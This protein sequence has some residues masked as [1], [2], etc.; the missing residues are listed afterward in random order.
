[1][2]I[3]VLSDIHGNAPALEAVLAD[4]PSV[5]AVVSCGDAVGY[6]PDAP[7]VVDRLRSLRVAMVR[8]NHELMVC[9]LKPV[10]PERAAAYRAE[11]TRAAL[12]PRQLRW[13]RTLPATLEFERDGLSICIRHASPWDEE[14]Y[15]YPDSPALKEIDLP[16]NH[17]LLLGHT[18]YPMQV[19]CGNGWLANPGSVGQPRDWNPQ[20]AY[21][22]LDT[23]TGRWEQRRVSYDHGAY[24][25]RLEA[26]GWEPR[27][28]A[29]LGR[30]RAEL[31]RS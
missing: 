13:L 1:M 4:L 27:T 7:A 24:Q 9:G 21:A 23:A 19:C 25:H 3:A 14:T 20:A 8:G 29:L 18:H 5:D 12:S 11:W 16:A 10:P 28:V 22:L 30:R 31:T 26:L 15:L 2:I 17:C 6:Y